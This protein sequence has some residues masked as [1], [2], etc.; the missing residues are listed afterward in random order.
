[1]PRVTHAALTM[2]A[3]ATLTVMALTSPAHAQKQEYDPWVYKE[4]VPTGPYLRNLEQAQ[5]VP[6]PAPSHWGALGKNGEFRAGM[7]R[8]GTDVKQTTRHYSNTHSLTPPAVDPAAAK[9]MA[10]PPRSA[11]PPPAPRTVQRP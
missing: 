2:S 7:Q 8:Y 3:V 9:R 1:M 6:G 10:A 11:D 4:M 5:P